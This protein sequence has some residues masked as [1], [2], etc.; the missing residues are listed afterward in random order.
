MRGLKNGNTEES[1]NHK[2]HLRYLYQVPFIKF[3]CFRIKFIVTYSEIKT[4]S[5]L[6]ENGR[7]IDDQKE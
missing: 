2:I 6:L 4:H 7:N 3:I 5:I 1:N